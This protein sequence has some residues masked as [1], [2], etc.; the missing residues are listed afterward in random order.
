MIKRITDHSFTR[1]SA[2]CS[3]CVSTSDSATGDLKYLH[4][5]TYSIGKYT[6]DAII[7]TYSFEG[8]GA[9]SAGEGGIVLSSADGVPDWLGDDTNRTNTGAY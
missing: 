5:N 9:E 7:V 4:V 8:V 6:G 3:T 1:G 2:G